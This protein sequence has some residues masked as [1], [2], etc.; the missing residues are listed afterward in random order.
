[1]SKN[2]PRR[3]SMAYWHRSR[4]KRMAPR[5]RH[6]PLNVP[7]LQ[8]LAGYKAGMIHVVMVDDRATPTKGQEITFPATLIEIPPLF[9]YAVNAFEKTYF[10]LKSLT[11]VVSL[12]APKD[13]KKVFNPAKK[14]KT[15]EDLKAMREKISELRLLCVTEPYKTGLGKK[16][17]ELIEIALGGSVDEEIVLAEKY[18]GQNIPL[19]EVITE[20]EF[21]DAIA[22]TKGKGWQGVVKRFGVALGIRKSTKKRR[23]GGT[24][25]AERPAKVFYTVPRAGQ[26]GYHKRT[27][28]N[29]RI[30]KLG[31]GS[32]IT[33]KEGFHNYGVVKGF[34]VLLAGSIPGPSKR[35]VLLRKTSEKPMKAELK[36]IVL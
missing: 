11:Q 33:P 30:L 29:K 24:L 10:G 25:G 26:M 35:L 5:I 6:W 31:F 17:P 20:G 8:G 1:M 36:E 4:A 3:G 21:V 28:K 23:H 27:E 32:E 18:L 2:K 14:G 16:K 13:L 12:K 7:G 9:V 34:Y 19:K 15:M 22:V